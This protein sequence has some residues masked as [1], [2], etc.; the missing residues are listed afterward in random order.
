LKSTTYILLTALLILGLVIGYY[1][2]ILSSPVQK[3]SVQVKSADVTLTIVPDVKLGPDGQMHDAFNPTNLTV[4]TGQVVNLTIINYDTMSHTFTSPSIGVSFNAP[5]ATKDG[6][7]T[8]MHYQFT[9]SKPG[10]YRWWCATPCDAWAMSTGS[11]GQIGQIGYM[12]GFVT[13]LSP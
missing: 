11:D 4:Y 2:A 8:V 13:V 1:V 12:G 7:P 5:G 10:V 3:G 9:V 6:V